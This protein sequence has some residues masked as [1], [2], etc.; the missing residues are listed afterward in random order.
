MRRFM[1]ISTSILSVVAGVATMFGWEP[2]MT[3]VA[4]VA[5]FALCLAAN[6]RDTQAEHKQ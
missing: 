2:P 6:A 5:F 1:Y 3:I 4:P